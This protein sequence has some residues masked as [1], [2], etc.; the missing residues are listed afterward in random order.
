MGIKLI[1][2]AANILIVTFQKSFIHSGEKKP[3]LMGEL[4]GGLLKSFD[5]RYLSARHKIN[6]KKNTPDLA[7]EN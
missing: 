1:V 2:C 3:D 7:D 6:W 4:F 5:L